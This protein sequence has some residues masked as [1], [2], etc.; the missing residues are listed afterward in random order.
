LPSFT[1]SWKLQLPYYTLILLTLWS[2]GVD[3]EYKY[4]TPSLIQRLEGLLGAVMF[5]PS[6]TNTPNQ[7]QAGI[8]AAQGRIYNLREERIRRQHEPALEVLREKLSRAARTPDESDEQYEH[9]SQ[10]FHDT[11]NFYR[12]A[13]RSIPKPET[14]LVIID[15][16]DRL[17]MASLEMVRDIFDR[18]EVGIVLVG[19]PGIEKRPA[20]YPQ[21]YSRVGFVHEFRPLT[22]KQMLSVLRGIWRPKGV[23]LP[24]KLFDDESLAAI[25]RITGGN[26]RLLHRLL[27]QIARVIEIN[28]LDHV[29]VPVV[30]AARESLVIGVA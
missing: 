30:D 8:Q 11:L 19:M 29:T 22:K 13:R 16:A 27:T 3:S 7:V 18:S 20:R 10:E 24:I 6:V 2:Y 5:T 4:N 15:E 12:Q 28:K 21:L 14:S 25:V 23:K 1:A 9:V 26:F 17:R